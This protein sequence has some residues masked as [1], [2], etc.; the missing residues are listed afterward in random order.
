MILKGR[1]VFSQGYGEELFS[2]KDVRKTI[3]A[4]L[5]RIL[6]DREIT[7]SGNRFKNF[8]VPTI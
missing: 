3:L 7:K 5:V 2:G 1:G 8:S 4:L 6:S